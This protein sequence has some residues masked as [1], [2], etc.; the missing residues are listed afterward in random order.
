MYKVLILG[1]LSLD[2]IVHGPEGVCVLGEPVWA[3]EISLLPGGS[4]FYA[5]CA[6]TGFGVDTHIKAA[7]GDDWEGD[8]LISALSKQGI[9]AGRVERVK[10]KSTQKCIVICD[11]PDKNFVSSS[12][13][14]GCIYE[15]MNLPRD[16]NLIYI[17]G[18][19]MY[20]EM[21]KDEFAG[22][23]SEARDKGIKVLLDTQCL[24]ISAEKVSGALNPSIVKNTDAILL[25]ANEAA[26]LSGK[27]AVEEAAKRLAEFG[28]SVVVIKLGEK[29]SFIYAMGKISRLPAYTVNIRDTVGAGD[30]FGAAFSYGILQD[31]SFDRTMNFANAAAALSIRDRKGKKGVPGLDEVLEFLTSQK[32]T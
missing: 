13:P 11:G 3:E 32:S 7:V 15:K 26:L 6:F 12:S 31:W 24:P 19:L 30:V 29:G 22:F 23:L 17:A 2:I 16:I 21:W 10:G 8:Y 14:I 27:G 28:A 4:A 25:N 5:G 1:E 9:D 18:Y 20:P